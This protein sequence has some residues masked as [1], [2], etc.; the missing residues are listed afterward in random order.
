MTYVTPILNHALNARVQF[1]MG[2]GASTIDASTVNSTVESKVAL[3]SNKESLETTDQT[4]SSLEVF[5]TKVDNSE[6]SATRISTCVSE[7]SLKEATI[8]ENRTLQTTQLPI[9]PGDPVKERPLYYPPPV[10]F[11]V[12]LSDDGIPME[13]KKTWPKKLEVLCH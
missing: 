7:D 3:E 6:K 4:V 2:C 11:D 1:V 12:P 5:D 8:A 10:A 13:K 9:V